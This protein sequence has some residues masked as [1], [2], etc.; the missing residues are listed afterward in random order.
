MNYEQGTAMTLNFPNPT[1]SFDKHNN[2]VR[3]W[4][5]DGAMEIAFFLET[6][7]LKALNPK[8]NNTELDVLTEFDKSLVR[9]HDIAEKVYRRSKSRSH[10]CTI[11]AHNF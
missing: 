10:A 1:R 6:A 7:A 9:I 5:Y 4:G 8:L 2:Y 11:T 3:F